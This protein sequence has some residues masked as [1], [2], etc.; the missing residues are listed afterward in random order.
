MGM[1]RWRLM[2]LGLCLMVAMPA[3]W[4]CLVAS[5]EP[6]R[7]PLVARSTPT[8]ITGP[9]ATQVPSSPTTSASPSPTS[10][11]PTQPVAPATAPPT[12][13]PA[14]TPAGGTYT[15]QPGDTLFGLARQTGVP[16]AEIARAN[17]L[18]P[19][20]QLVIGQQLRIPASDAA[21][22]VS[23]IRVTSPTSGA[24]VRVPIVV[25]GSAATFEGMVT[26]EVL[27]ASG[28]QLARGTASAAMPQPGDLGPFRAEIA[29]PPSSVERRVTLR[30][31]WNNP[32]D[33]SP[34]DELRI[35]LT[36]APSI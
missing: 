28:S 31:Y 13:P 9:T 3:L 18:P 19:D 10:L 24:T 33:G 2:A 29:V 17:G 25:Q 6:A 26:L 8:V 1:A 12:T 22:P 15:V 27:D 30:I 16:P 32:R 11:R 36:L 23:G 21:P 35:P 5:E 7:R 4:G 14:V 20:A 34:M